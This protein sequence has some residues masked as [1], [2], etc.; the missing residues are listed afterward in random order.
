MAALFAQH[1]LHLFLALALALPLGW[2]VTSLLRTPLLV[3]GISRAAAALGRRLNK[4]KRGASTLAWRGVIVTAIFTLPA[5]ALG[6]LV[7]AHWLLL[8]VIFSFALDGGPMLRRWR[9]ARAGKLGLSITRPNYLFPDHHAL[10]RY[11]ILTHSRYFAVGIVGVSFWT[12]LLG[13]AGAL[14]YLALALAASHYA[15]EHDD[16]LAFGG[17]ATRLFAGADALPRLLAALLLALAGLFVPGSRP[18][19]AL[20]RLLADWPRFLAALLHITLGGPI[21]LARRHYQLP[22][23]GEGTAK[24]EAADLTRWLAVWAVALLMLLVLVLPGLSISR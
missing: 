22:W 8:T 4:A 14:G 12:L 17:V 7:G 9:Q 13:G 2:A 15:T 3:D 19:A 21:P 23:T 24:L 6:A 18:R 5:I 16:N 20:P 10:L 1:A 11:A